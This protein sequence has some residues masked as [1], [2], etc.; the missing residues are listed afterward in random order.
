MKNR[1]HMHW[2]M[3]EGIALR[4]ATLTRGVIKD[5]ERAR[6]IEWARLNFVHGELQGLA[7]S[8]KGLMDQ[9]DPEKAKD[10]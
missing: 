5:T 3:V 6:T 4:L 7:D 10:Q 9:L 1:P 8:V 2:D